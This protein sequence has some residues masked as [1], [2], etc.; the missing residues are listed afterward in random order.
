M[1][2]FKKHDAMRVAVIG[3]TGFTGRR[4]VRE[5]SGRGHDVTALVRAPAAGR[6]PP[7][8]RVLEADMADRAALAG[9]LEGQ[10]A[11]VH[12]ASLGFGHA[13]G[14]VASVKA[15]GVERSIFFSTTA[16]FTRLPAASKAV[17]LAAEHS[18]RT[19]PGAWTIL[20][21][22]MI[23]GDAGDRNL[24]RLIRFVARC[25]IV[26]LPGGG[27]ALLQ[28]VHVD[29]LARAAVQALECDAAARREYDLPGAEAMPL[30]EL[31]RQVA[32]LLERRALLLPLP[33]APTATL[34]GLWHRFGLAPRVS[35]EQVWRLAEDKAFA[36][37]A[38]RR[39]WGYSPR[40][41]REGLAQEVQLLRGE[42]F[43]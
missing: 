39:D 26:P 7:G 21:P 6:T 27:R 11:F 18:V 4:V 17:R 12:V 29:D 31:V 19:L 42:G 23:Y 25:P 41:L 32:A 13:D 16:I 37:D 38:A 14:L 1:A 30:R 3:A 10:D 33:L 35:A 20:R 40:G 5:L 15:A 8:L 9:L 28:P 24:S 2:R 34:A 22:T 36:F 43:I